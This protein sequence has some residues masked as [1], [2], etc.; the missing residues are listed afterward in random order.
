MDIKQDDKLIILP[1]STKKTSLLENLHTRV[2]GRGESE[3]E[4]E[5]GG[6]RGGGRGRDLFKICLKYTIS[7]KK[8]GGGEWIPPPLQKILSF[9]KTLFSPKFV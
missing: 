1:K 2:R 7:A 5:R 4:E 6:R 3:R 9:L 8:I